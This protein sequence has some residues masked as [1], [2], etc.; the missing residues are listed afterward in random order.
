MEAACRLLKSIMED[1]HY[2]CTD[3]C[4][5]ELERLC[6]A[7]EVEAALVSDPRTYLLE[8]SAEVE[9][10][11]VTLLG[12]YVDEETLEVV[13]KIGRGVAGVRSLEYKPGYAPYLS[14][15]A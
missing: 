12:P 10:G 7:A 8:M 13:L 2:S 6:L 3:G 9:D 11:A 4:E 14:P 1:E 15:T 5:R